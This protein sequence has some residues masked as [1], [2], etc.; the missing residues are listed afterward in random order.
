MTCLAAAVWMISCSPACSCHEREMPMM[1]MWLHGEAH[2]VHRCGC[3]L[4]LVGFVGIAA[5]LQNAQARKC[6]A[7]PLT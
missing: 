6:C 7:A 3:I 5:A 2:D 4:G 1:C